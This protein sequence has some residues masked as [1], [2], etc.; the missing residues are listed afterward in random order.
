MNRLG[1]G[2]RSGRIEGEALQLNPQLI[3]SHLAD[4]RDHMMNSKQLKVFLELT[5]DIT[6]PKSLAATGAYCWGE[7]SLQPYSSV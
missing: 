4:D 2:L 5:N 7:I 1:M 3:M 6:V